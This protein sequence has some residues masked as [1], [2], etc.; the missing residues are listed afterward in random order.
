MLGADQ[1]IEFMFERDRNPSV[2][3]QFKSTSFHVSFLSWVE[4]NFIAQLVKHCSA[5]AEFMGSN[6]AVKP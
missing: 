5:H 2:F 3:P 1:F 4:K 6:P